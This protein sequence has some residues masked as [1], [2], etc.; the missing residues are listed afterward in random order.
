[1]KFEEVY[2]HALAEATRENLEEITRRACIICDVLYDGKSTADS[3][4]RLR[5]SLE[6]IFGH[7]LPESEDVI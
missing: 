5:K 1:M 2:E 4:F 7:D 6:S 3:L